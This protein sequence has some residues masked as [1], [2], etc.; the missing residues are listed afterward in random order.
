[1]AS[2]PALQVPKWSSVFTQHINY[3]VALVRQEVPLG[4][5]KDI[6]IQRQHAAFHGKQLSQETLFLDL[7][8]IL[9][10]KESC[11]FQ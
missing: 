4:Y 10:C 1:M 3:L 11:V 8:M 7:G 2:S 5:R 9:H 6:F